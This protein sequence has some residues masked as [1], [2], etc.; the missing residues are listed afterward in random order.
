MLKNI[1]YISAAQKR[2]SKP[3]QMDRTWN[4][5]KRYWLILCFLAGIVAGT[6]FVNLFCVGEYNKFGIYGQYFVN[7]FENASI[8]KD[9]L[10]L[11]SLWNRSKEILLLILFAFTSFGAVLPEMFLVYKG[12]TISTLIGVYVIQYGLGGLLIFLLG[13]FPHYITY[14]I[15]IVFLV[16]FSRELYEDF[17]N[18]R[19]KNQNF[20][21]DK[22][23]IITY[24]KCIFVIIALNMITSYLET[25]INLKI[26]K[27]IF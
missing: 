12:I 24:L 15:M 19:Y 5:K 2:K 14:T 6:I 16:L 27:N 25:F 13:I 26:V 3:V 21:L 9:K 8:E 17:K 18:V 7:K 4:L 23:K 22:R 20:L 1:T 11:Y 10:F